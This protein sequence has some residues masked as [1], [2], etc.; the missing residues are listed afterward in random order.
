MGKINPQ[1]QMPQLASVVRV[2]QDGIRSINVESDL[3]NIT[4]SESYQ[5]TAQSR[6]CLNRIISR[7]NGGT[8]TRAWTLTGPYGSGKS[9]FGLNLMNLFCAAQP[10]HNYALKQLKSIDPILSHQLSQV[11]S[12]NSTHGLL[13]VPITGYRASIQECLKHGLVQSLQPIPDEHLQEILSELVEW[14]P[15][16]ESRFL[17]QWISK[18]LDVLTNSLLDYSGIL[19]IF[20]EMGKPLEYAAT[21]PDIADV[22]FMQ[23]LAEFANRTGNKPVLFMGILHQ[24][25]ERYAAL[26]DHTTQREWSKVQG[27]FEDIAFQEPPNLQ[28]RLVRNA[29][30]VI[31]QTAIAD[32]QPL[33]NHTVQEASQNNW[34]PPLVKLEE[35]DEL[36]KHS[37]PLHPSVLVA[38]PILFRRLAQNERSIFV[39]LASHEPFGFQELILQKKL[40]EFIRISDLFDYVTANLQGRLYA[41]GRARILTETFERLGNGYKLELIEADLLK[42]I[43]LLNWLSEVSHINATESCLFTALR[44][45]DRT[46]DDIK[47]AL[48]DLQKRSLIIFRRFNRTYTIWQGSDVDID[49]RLQEAQQKLSGAF[50]L[51]EAVQKYLPPRPLVAKRHSYITGTLR[52]FEVQYVDAFIRNQI[53]LVPSF[54]SSGKV[55]LCLPTNFADVDAFREWAHEND[56]AN[57]PDLLI[58]VTERTARLVELLQELRCLHWVKENTPELRDD[59]V[60]RRELRA[61]VAAVETL[62][63]NEIGRSLSLHRL[64]DAAG[65]K[66]YYLGKEIELQP[67]DGLSHQ[68]S[69]IC[70]ELFPDSPR[71]WN[72]LINRRTLSSQGAAARR[73]LIEAILTRSNQPDLGINGY[74]PERSMYESLLRSSGLHHQFEGDNWSFGDPQPEDHCHLRPAW[75]AIAE[76]IFAQPPEPRPVD[77]LFNRLSSPP[78]GLTE[79]VL[80]LLLCVYLAIHQNEATLY[81]EGSLLP[82][83]NVPDWEVLLRRPEL[84]QIAGCR[85]MGTKA[86]ILDRFARGLRTDPAVMAVVRSLV[87]MLKPLPEYTLKTQQLAPGSLALRN[88]ILNAHSPE[89]LIFYDLPLALGL[90]PFGDRPP[91]N[92]EVEIF[93]DR[94][95]TALQELADSS[96]KMQARA[97]DIFLEACELPTG[98]SGWDR[99]SAIATE[100]APHVSNPSLAPLLKRASEIQNSMAALESVLAYIANRPPR[101]WS[102]YDVERFPAQAQFLGNLFKTERNG[103]GPA[104]DLPEALRVRSR[105][106]A[107]ELLEHMETEYVEDPEVLQAA[108]QLLSQQ[109]R[110]LLNRH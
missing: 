31:D 104:P 106:I 24:A 27:R 62:I 84:F 92:G 15:D 11:L 52:Y 91:E 74:P 101:S 82:E 80:P 96:P 59:P 78:Y 100:L 44:S 12:L 28:M 4:I 20:D 58:G 110:K 48:H 70:D 95:N 41:S 72:E 47:Q 29:I 32:I 79:G 90:D 2:R 75:D 14:S 64:A 40:P 5:L 50:S 26:L 89:R 38:L 65:S 57:H 61:R 21:H 68:L 22:F 16:N 88:A 77:E 109:Y 67:R 51:A 36:C 3:Q 83:P 87:R 97:R 94:L 8:P 19:F 71:L 105:Q 103:F 102:D 17:I 45:Y 37:F 107:Q 18:L 76:Y 35:F 93:F 23:E 1:K 10:A 33:I 81:R 60:A 9:F 54:G 63:Q 43:G 69:V 98:E 25:F 73:N 85:V 34:C 42:T 55:L 108:L 56:V 39:Y 86:A 46:D 99:F 30:E 53:E 66:W 13:P 49:E 6:Y 7:F